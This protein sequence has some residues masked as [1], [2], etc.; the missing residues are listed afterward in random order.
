MLVVSMHWYGP[1]PRLAR[2]VEPSPPPLTSA[3]GLVWLARPDDAAAARSA[4]CTPKRGRASSARKVTA[5][6]RTARSAAHQAGASRR[7]REPAAVA[8]ASVNGV[9]AS[10]RAAPN[11]VAASVRRCA[12]P[13]RR[14]PVTCA[15]CQLAWHLSLRRGQQL[16]LGTVLVVPARA[17]ARAIPANSGPSVAPASAAVASARS[18][19]REPC[20]RNLDCCD[21]TTGLAGSVVLFEQ[22]RLPRDCLL[23]LRHGSL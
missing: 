22:R 1:S 21:V 4:R 19:L 13:G 7:R 11:H 2:A 18:E 5:T 14:N 23:R 8:A 16:L 3:V 20:F 17:R 9:A 10:V 15:C 6:E 12:V